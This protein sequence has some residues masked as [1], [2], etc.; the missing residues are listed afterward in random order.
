MATHSGVLA[1]RSPS[2]E[3][4]GGLQSTRRTESVTPEGPEH[5]RTHAHT[6]GFQQQQV[7]YKAHYVPKKAK[8]TNITV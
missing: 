8:Q 6:P 1:W 4:P 5:A 3:E 2:T 7:N